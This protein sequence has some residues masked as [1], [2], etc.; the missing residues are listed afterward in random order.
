MRTFQITFDKVSYRQ[1]VNGFEIPIRC[2]IRDWAQRR[3]SYKLTSM[4]LCLC[5][6]YDVHQGQDFDS[7]KVVQY[8]VTSWPE[9]TVPSKPGSVVELYG[10]LQRHQQQTGCSSSP[11][12]VHCRFVLNRN[13]FGEFIVLAYPLYTLAIASCGNTS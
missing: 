5:L 2:R 3:I 12:V 6:V 13:S 4:A 10:H 11:V 7:R 8:Q 1:N 9:G